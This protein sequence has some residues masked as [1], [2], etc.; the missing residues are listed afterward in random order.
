MPETHQ[1]GLGAEKRNGDGVGE[2][3]MGREIGKDLV[4]TKTLKS[5]NELNPKRMR[6]LRR[7]QNE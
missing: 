4:K 1:K 5:A 7:R 3:D 6:D 2:T